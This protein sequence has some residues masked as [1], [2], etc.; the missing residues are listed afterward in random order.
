MSIRP[1]ESPKYRLSATFVDVSWKCQDFSYLSFS[2]AHT[3]QSGG[4]MKAISGRRC[5]SMRRLCAQFRTARGPFRTAVRVFTK[6]I[7]VTDSYFVN[8]SY[9]CPCRRLNVNRR[10]SERR[11]KS[12]FSHAESRSWKAKGHPYAESPEGTRGGSTHT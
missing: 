3:R 10:N 4:T 8:Y 12:C 7:V 9:L 6:K 2:A 1:F 11:T 5:S